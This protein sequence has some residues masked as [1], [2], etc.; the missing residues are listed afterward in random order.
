MA[1]AE[2]VRVTNLQLYYQYEF[3]QLS[4]IHA[5]EIAKFM[6]RY[7]NDLV[8]PVFKHYFTPLKKVHNYCTRSQRNKV[9]FT[10]QVST[11]VDKTSLKYMG[12]Q[13]WGNVPPETK[14]SS[15]HVFSKK[16]KKYFLLK[17]SN[18]S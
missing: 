17:Y 11:E 4:D 12:V 2:K 10:P 16:L 18:L 15:V 1:F 5:L 14:K 3:L 6:H 7:E 13:V 8:P 9:F